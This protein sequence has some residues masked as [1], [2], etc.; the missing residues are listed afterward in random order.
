MIKITNF[1]TD[2]LYG[3]E[4]DLQNKDAKK[5]GEDIAEFIKNFW[6]HLDNDFNTPAAFGEFFK[7]L[8]YFY[9]LKDLAPKPRDLILEFLQDINKIFNIIDE[10][11]ITK[12]ENIP[13]KIMDLVI[14]RER[15]RDEKDFLGADKLRKIVEQYEYVIEDKN[16]GPV[17]KKK[18]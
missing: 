17:V 4:G 12:P 16:D 3:K 11:N 2:V 6:N 15:L 14:E 18:L 8:N 1:W 7:L 5:E 10:A 9:E 13:T